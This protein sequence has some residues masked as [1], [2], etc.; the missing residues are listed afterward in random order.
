MKIGALALIQVVSA[1]NLAHH[2]KHHSNNAE[3]DYL[4]NQHAD[5]ERKY[6]AVSNLLDIGNEIQV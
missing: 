5:Y 3:V 1:V 4:M 2:H 6:N